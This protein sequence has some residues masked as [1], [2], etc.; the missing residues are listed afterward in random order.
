MLR[1][2]AKAEA[3]MMMTMTVVIR[4][5]ATRPKTVTGVTP[6][7]AIRSTGTL[8]GREIARPEPIGV[9]LTGSETV[10]EEPIGSRQK[11]A[12]DN[13]AERSTANPAG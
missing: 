10:K 8:T 2:T 9:V 6:N 11:A 13:L 1:D 12:P 3:M 4:T 5:S 7:E